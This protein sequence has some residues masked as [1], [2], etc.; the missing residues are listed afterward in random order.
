[1]DYVSK[2]I[3]KAD[4]K[5]LQLFDPVWVSGCSLLHDPFASPGTLTYLREVIE[6]KSFLMANAPS[7][8]GNSGGGL[9]EGKSGNLLGLTSRVTLANT[10]FGVDIMTWMEFSTHPE[11]LYEFFE[12]NE[13]QFLYDPKDDY[14]AAADRRERKRKDAVRQLLFEKAPEKPQDGPGY[15]YDPGVDDER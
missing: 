12:H 2:V 6:Q 10:M 14:Y 4:I 15:P 11:R 13:L 3:P 7:V 5:N 1:M 9:F 8:F